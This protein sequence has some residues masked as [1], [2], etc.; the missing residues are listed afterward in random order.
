MITARPFVAMFCDLSPALIK[1]ERFECFY[2][3]Y[4]LSRF[5]VYLCWD[6]VSETWDSEW[7]SLNGGYLGQLFFS[8]MECN[9]LRFY[10]AATDFSKIFKMALAS[11]HMCCNVVRHFVRRATIYGLP[12][13]PRIVTSIDR[14]LASLC[15]YNGTFAILHFWRVIVFLLV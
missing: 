7:D 9:H 2:N 12:R 6:G 5:C 10:P 4:K 15:V 14:E 13:R 3:K 8:K 1:E 11:V